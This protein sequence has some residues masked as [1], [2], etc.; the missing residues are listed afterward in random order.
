MEMIDDADGVAAEPD[1]LAD[2]P[3]DAA[4]HAV[5]DSAIRT[6]AVQPS[7]CRLPPR[8]TLILSTLVSLR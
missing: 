8:P 6:A 1:T 7:L 4:V 2:G 5:A 3:E